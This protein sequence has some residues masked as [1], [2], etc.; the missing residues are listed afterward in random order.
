MI[1]PQHEKETMQTI[2]NVTAQE[3]KRENN[4]PRRGSALLCAMCYEKSHS[5]SCDA[6]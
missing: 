6:A 1:L 3:T 5:V 4:F 2:I